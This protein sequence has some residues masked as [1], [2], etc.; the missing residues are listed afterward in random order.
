M[1][2]PKTIRASREVFGIDQLAHPPS[3]PEMLGCA[4][5]MSL[6][7]THIAVQLSAQTMVDFVHNTRDHYEHAAGTAKQ[8]L[9]AARAILHLN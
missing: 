5:T 3:I 2:R 9:D 4:A 7:A 1:G 8:A 6:R